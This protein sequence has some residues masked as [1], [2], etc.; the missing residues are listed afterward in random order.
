MENNY[1]SIIESLKGKIEV[2]IS[3]YEQARADN[4]QLKRELEA[5]KEELEINKN[6]TAELEDKIDKLQLADAFK[7]SSTDG[8]EAKRKIGKI[9]KEIDKC[10]A[11][12]ND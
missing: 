3:G 2:I 7:V 4:Y 10:I 5:C 11:L 9:I 8:K 6:K 12:L 1:Q